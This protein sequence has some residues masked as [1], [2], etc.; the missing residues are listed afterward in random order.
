MSTIFKWDKNNMDTLLATCETDGILPYIEKYMPAP[1]RVLES[2]CGAGRYVKYLYDRGWDV[3]GLEWD[4]DA[5]DMIKDY[6]PEVNAVQGDSANSPFP[7]NHFD[8]IISLGVIEHWIE[9]PE[10]PLKDIYRTLKPGAAAIITAPCL[11][12]IRKIKKTVWW[13]E[14]VT[15]KAATKNWRENAG[16]Q[17]NRLDSKFKYW[18]YPTYGEFFEYRFTKKEFIDEIKKQG[19]EIVEHN[20]VAIIDGVYHELN[21]KHKLVK[22]EDRQFIPTTMGKLVNKTFSAVPFFHPHH[23]IAIVRK[24]LKKTKKHATTK[25]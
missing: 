12:T 18:P 13:N 6:W 9:G 1:S 15:E 2:G 5:V 23:Q 4:Q 16:P 19:F 22:Y 25:K 8:G 7:D 17:P 20:P 21:P 14:K 11:N 24:P 3:I 10:A